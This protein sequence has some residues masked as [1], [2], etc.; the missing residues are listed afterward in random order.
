MAG[1]PRTFARVLAGD[2]D[3][4]EWR[5]GDGDRC[6]RHR[7]GFNAEMAAVSSLAPVIVPP[8]Q[9]DFWLDCKNIDEKWQ[10]N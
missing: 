10:P 2:L 8:E 9:F 4:T 1:G 5:E 3:R 6:H 7:P